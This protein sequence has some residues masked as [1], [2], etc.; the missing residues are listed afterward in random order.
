MDGVCKSNQPK[1]EITEVE[2]QKDFPTSSC[3]GISKTCW[4]ITLIIDDHVQKVN[5][6]NSLS[7]TNFK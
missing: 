3:S 1:L 5:M 2:R 7:V 6:E 4:F